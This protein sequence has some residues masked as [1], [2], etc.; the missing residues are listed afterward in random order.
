M[1]HSPVQRSVSMLTDSPH[2]VLAWRDARSSPVVPRRTATQAHRAT[3]PTAWRY[4]FVTLRDADDT[5]SGEIGGDR[6]N[7]RHQRSPALGI[8]GARDFRRTNRRSS[9]AFVEQGNDQ[10]LDRGAHSIACRR[11]RPEEHRAGRVGIPQ[12]LA[13]VGHGCRGLQSIDSVSRKSTPGLCPALRAF[14]AGRLARPAANR[15]VSRRATVD[16]TYRSPRMHSLCTTLFVR[17]RCMTFSS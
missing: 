11:V 14:S 17:H 12:R 5:G 15:Y 2:A 13:G 3:P 16:R 4:N 7:R 1:C 10:P 6:A 9:G 8:D